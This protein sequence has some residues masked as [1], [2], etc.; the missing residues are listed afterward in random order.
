MS[1]HP[2][3]WHVLILLVLAGAAMIVFAGDE[4][5]RWNNG[6]VN[7]GSGFIGAVVTFL[8]FERYLPQIS[9]ADGSRHDG[10]SYSAFAAHVKR[11]RSRVR[12]LSTF[13]YPLTTHPEF[14]K[15]KREFVDAVRQ[16]VERNRGIEIRLLLLDPSS[17]AAKQRAE[18]RRDDDVIRRIR[19]NLSE[20]HHLREDPYHREWFRKVEVKLYDRLP[21]LSVFQWDDRASMSYYPRGKKITETVRFEFATDTPLGT[22]MHETFEDVWND[23]VTMDLD[24]YVFLG[25]RAESNATGRTL[26]SRVHYVEGPSGGFCALLN[27]DRDEPVLAL[28]EG[29]LADCSVAVVRGKTLLPCT[30]ARLEMSEQVRRLATAKYGHFEYQGMLELRPATGR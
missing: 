16:A 5:T 21:P 27:V 6:L 24:D 8:L 11:S 28:L 22:F 10:F 3:P 1:V 17:E 25:L 20:L 15:E 13:V 30:C 12:V 26:A 23:P 4:G 29:G 2:R 19:E 18:E 9:S 7:V 14:Q